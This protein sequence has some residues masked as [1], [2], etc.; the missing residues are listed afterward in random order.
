MRRLLVVV[1][2][3][4]SLLVLGAGIL[5]FAH[6]RYA[7]VPGKGNVLSR[8]RASPEAYDLWGQS[9]TEEEAAR[10]L[11][12]SE[13][14]STLSPGNGAVKV[15]EALLRLGRRSFYE[16]TFGNERFLTDVVGILNG[17]LRISN[18]T[19]AILAL[20]GGAT[21][22]LRV[23]APETVKIGNKT[24]GKGSYFD[25]GL[26]VPRGALVPLGMAISVSG[27][28][29][30]AGITCALCHATVDAETGKV[31]EGA[32]NQDFN[33]GLLL[34]LGTN[35][36]AYFMHTDVAPLRDVP[37]DR[38]HTI[39]SPNGEKE[40]LPNI[41]ALEDAVDSALLMWP[42]G[43]FDSLTDMKADPTQN[44]VSF[45][46]G[47]HPYG[48]SGNF[49]AGPFRGLTSQNN[50][51]HA[52][53]S[54][55]LLLADASQTMFDLDKEMFLATVL[56]NAA[57]KHYRFD[58]ESSRTPSEQLSSANGKVKGPGM[59]Q[60]VLPPTY[61][62]GTILSPDGTLT[63]SPGYR[64]WEQ[65][66]A[67]AA[68][69]DTI[70]PPKARMG[71]SNAARGRAVFEKA[72]CPGCHAG[73]FLTDNK[74]IPS[75][76]IGTNP[77]RSLALAKT[78]LSFTTP[79]VYAF[80]TPVPL[81][82]QP[83]LLEVPTGH[84]DARQVDLAWAHHG[85]GGGYKVPALVGLYWSAP[86]LHDGGVAVGRNASTD[87]GLPGTVEVNRMPDPFNSLKA[88]VDRELRARV[89]A[90]NQASPDLRRMNV[91]GIGHSYWVDTQSGF[92][93]DQQSAL[94]E[95]LLTYDPESR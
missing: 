37:S 52:L 62:K 36:A 27:L 83:K 87:L 67:M 49:M 34:A 78:E 94:I 24:F 58:A 17:P 59:N 85:S 72:G 18:V 6:I 51:V 61:P 71:G 29:I 13:G 76:E 86:Y 16:E 2:V 57:D 80:D 5:T 4:V 39:L 47:N 84:L 60:V 28:R 25:T 32:P 44:P 93:S 35:S 22:N 54:D 10:V 65:N 68:W 81:P 23:E 31:V 75:I 43:N 45:T 91:E 9:F 92:T 95:Y 69:Q 19:K 1:F 42:R 26:D 89:V 46:W 66:N 41:A 90:A 38:A 20:H 73:S 11:Q 50:N 63:S 56:Q 12:N 3:G 48:W 55:S 53:N 40:A 70:V 64:F 79:V 7:Y 74:I 33:A 21:T 8:T 88:L 82:P 30:R 15:D 77:V 14:K